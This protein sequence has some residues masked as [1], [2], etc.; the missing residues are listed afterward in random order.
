MINHLYALFHGDIPIVPSCCVGFWGWYGRVPG[1]GFKA[2]F[3]KLTQIAVCPRVHVIYPHSILSRDVSMPPPADGLFFCR[4]WSLEKQILDRG[5]ARSWLSLLEGG[6]STSQKDAHSATRWHLEI[7]CEP[8]NMHGEK[9]PND[10][11]FSTRGSCCTHFMSV[12]CFG[13]LCYR[14]RHAWMTVAWGCFAE[15]ILGSCAHTWFRCSGWNL[16]ATA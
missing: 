4:L 5:P 15:H 12:H 2:T 10:W 16:A 1:S 6:Q 14:D 11:S 8:T 7:Q 13:F 3:K 9:T